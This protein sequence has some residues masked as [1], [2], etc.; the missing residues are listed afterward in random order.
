MWPDSTVVMALALHTAAYLGSISGTPYGPP[1]SLGMTSEYKAKS[2]HWCAT[3]K[4]SF[5]L[6]NMEELLGCI[7]PKSMP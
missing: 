7:F 1:R 4:I 6:F 5:I 3:S 2:K